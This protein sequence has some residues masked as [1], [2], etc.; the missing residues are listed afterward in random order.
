MPSL[1]SKNNKQI[2]GGT[3]LHVI[4]IMSDF[5]LEGFAVDEFAVTLPNKRLPV[6]PF[7]ILDGDELNAADLVVSK[8]IFY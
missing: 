7:D 5:L 2:G 1:N 6:T 3:N 8:M 4:K